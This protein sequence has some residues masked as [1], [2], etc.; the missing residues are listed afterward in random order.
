[1]LEDSGRTR[2]VA[3]RMAEDL[4]ASM[5]R[6]AEQEQA[7]RTGPASLQGAAGQ[8][9][10][11][12]LARR[13]Y[14]RGQVDAF[15]RDIEAENHRMQMRLGGLERTMKVMAAQTR[16]QRARFDEIEAQRNQGA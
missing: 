7:G 13:G 16:S 10:T 5:V 6:Q 4:L 15:L 11:F 8:P 1:M 2:E 14:D 12:P 3:Q 9:A